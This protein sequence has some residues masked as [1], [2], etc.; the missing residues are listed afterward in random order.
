MKYISIIFTLTILFSTSLFAQTIIINKDN[1]LKSLSQQQIRNIFLGNTNAWD[2]G[3][4]IQ[5]ADYSANSDLR[6]NFSSNFLNLSPRKVSM[7]WIKVTLSGKSIPPKIFD[8][9]SEVVKFVNKTKG[10]IGYISSEFDLLNPVK[11]ITIE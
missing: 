5:I 11:I 10:A 9:E 2:N 3:I 6:N 7:I 4:F 1:P 8:S